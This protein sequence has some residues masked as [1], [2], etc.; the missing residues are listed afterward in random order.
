MVDWG[1]SSL[2][3]VIAIIGSGLIVTGFSSLA[4]FI[5]NPLLNI[6]VGP[7][8]YAYKGDYSSSNTTTI[9]RINL[10]NS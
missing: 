9:Y 5:N 1:G 8:H 4:S 10:T 3:I 6:D 7:I 2:Q